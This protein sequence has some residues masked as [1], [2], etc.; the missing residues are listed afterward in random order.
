MIQRSQKRETAHRESNYAIAQC[1]HFR[2]Q[3]SD[4]QAWHILLDRGGVA[5]L[6]PFALHRL[7]IQ[8]LS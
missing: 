7:L 4:A 1:L 3:E 5:T 2:H 8:R 6:K